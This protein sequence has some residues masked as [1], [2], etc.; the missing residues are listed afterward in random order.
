MPRDY[1]HRIVRRRKRL[2]VSPWLGMGAGLLLGGLAA[3]VAYYKL[4]AQAPPQQPPAPA[5]LPE[6]PAPPAKATPPKTTPP[7]EAK[8]EEKTAEPAPPKPRFDFYTILP[9][10]EVVIPEEETG[11][12]SAPIA[13]RPEKK[14]E[15]NPLKKSVG[16]PAEKPAATATLPSEPRV[17]PVPAAR[18]NYFLQTDSFRSAEQADR[19]KAQ[20]AMLGLEASVHKVTINNKNTYYRVR[21]GPFRDFNTLDQARAQ[22]RQ[23]GI[24]STPMMIG[25]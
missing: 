13:V 1:K 17:K 16:K 24:Q 11:A 4:L 21:V 12:K 6:T 22:L 18:G 7:G 2:L 3:A 9:E 5:F 15:E 20:S 25:R 19:V 23:R 10:M 8:R 14:A